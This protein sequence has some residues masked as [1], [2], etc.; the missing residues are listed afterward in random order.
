MRPKTVGWRALSVTMLLALV[1]SLALSV[2]Q[3][4]EA[5]SNG[6]LKVAPKTRTVKVTNFK[7]QPIQI[8][9]VKVRDK[10]V[11]LNEGFVEEDDWIDHLRYVVKNVSV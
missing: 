4:N 5:Q 11:P 1:V 10:S 2:T 8:V 6:K 7:G 9:A 3:S